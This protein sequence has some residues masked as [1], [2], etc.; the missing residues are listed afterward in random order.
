LL[1]FRAFEQAAIPEA[2]LEIFGDGPERR[3]LE[4]F[5]R[6]RG[7]AA[8][9]VFHGAVPRQSV[10]ARLDGA[11]A[12]VHLSPEESGGFVCLEAMAAGVPPIVLTAGGPAELVPEGSG[13]RIDVAD[14]E[15][16]VH[17]AAEAM[18]R[19]ATDPEFQL[20]LGV[21]GRRHIRRHGTWR[22]KISEIESIHE[23][24]LSMEHG[25]SP[26]ANRPATAVE[27]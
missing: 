15:T 16:V 20:K 2:R 17:T 21:S 24:V 4:E 12:L 23:L 25:S 6:R 11:T 19:L 7:L 3:L 5:V 10:L 18:H 26:V 14:D 22:T 13:V 8:R 1:C 9:V 27:D